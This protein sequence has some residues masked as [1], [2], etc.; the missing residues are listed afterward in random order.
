[1]KTCQTSEVERA[2]LFDMEFD[3]FVMVTAQRD[4]DRKQSQK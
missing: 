3:I 2:E 4:K 1:M